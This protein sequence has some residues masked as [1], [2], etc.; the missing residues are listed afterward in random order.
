MLP[1]CL[2]S[3]CVCWQLLFKWFVHTGA[4]W[5]LVLCSSYKWEPQDTCHCLFSHQ[6]TQRI[7]TCMP[8]EAKPAGMKARPYL[9]EQLPKNDWKMGFRE[10]GSSSKFSLLKFL[11]W[12]KSCW[13]NNRDAPV[14]VS[15]S[16]FLRFLFSGTGISSAFYPHHITRTFS[17]LCLHPMTCWLYI[18]KCCPSSEVW[19]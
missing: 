17:P 10:M 14:L 7:A 6:R 12:T 9:H 1:H 4:G 8:S 3:K 5:W 15:P 13:H 18:G 19:W 16:L 2:W 11:R